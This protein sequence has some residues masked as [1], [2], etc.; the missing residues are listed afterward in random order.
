LATDILLGLFIALLKIYAYFNYILSGMGVKRA[1][2]QAAKLLPSA[3]WLQM[4]KGG[5][6]ATGQG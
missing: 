5:G 3:V 6:H 2:I 1:D 4:K